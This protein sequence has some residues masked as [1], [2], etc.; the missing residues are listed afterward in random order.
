MLSSAFCGKVQINSCF[1][2]PC[3]LISNWFP[4]YSLL[5]WTFFYWHIFRKRKKGENSSA[6]T[7]KYFWLQY[8]FPK[9]ILPWWGGHN[10]KGTFTIC[11]KLRNVFGFVKCSS[12]AFFS[13]LAKDVHCAYEVWKSQFH[14]EQE[15]E[16][17][18][19]CASQCHQ[20]FNCNTMPCLVSWGDVQEWG[21]CRALLVLRH[22]S[23]PSRTLDTL[24]KPVTV[25]LSLSWCAAAT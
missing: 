7:Q 4:I 20:E 19:F 17:S 8:P 12:Y 13:L 16:F 14:S 21:S 6:K 1:I 23:S 10:K 25:V 2:L 11:F 5:C 9:I 24:I 18:P 22:W 3:I 15:A